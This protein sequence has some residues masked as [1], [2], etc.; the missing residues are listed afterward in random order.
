M[1]RLSKKNADGSYILSVGTEAAA[2]PIY[3]NAAAATLELTLESLLNVGDVAVT[4]SDEGETINY[5][6]EFLTN[7]GNVPPISIEL[8]NLSMLPTEQYPF[9][10]VVMGDRHALSGTTLRDA[11][12]PLRVQARW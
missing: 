7:E 12:H 4:K 1:L 5:L 11:I 6:I 2:M 10:S 3:F 9:V 8:S